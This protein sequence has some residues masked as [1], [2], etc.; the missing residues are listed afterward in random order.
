MFDA[1]VFCQG[2]DFI[3]PFSAEYQESSHTKHLN[4]ER[5]EIGKNIDIKFRDLLEKD[6]FKDRINLYF[7]ISSEHGDLPLYYRPGESPEK[8]TL[9]SIYTNIINTNPSDCITTIRLITEND[10]IQYNNKNNPIVTSLNVE[11]KLYESSVI[12]QLNYRFEIQR[13][14]SDDGY[15]FQNSKNYIAVGTSEI[16]YEKNNFRDC[17]ITFGPSNK[18]YSHYKRKYQ[19]IQSLLADTMS[20]I[21]ILI[22]IGK[23]ISKV[24]LKKKMN[25]DIVRNLINRNIYT[26]I[27]EC[28]LIE[29]N[30]KEKNYLKYK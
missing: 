27:K 19:K 17:L 24:L 3:D 1:S 2:N 14:E 21:N 11:S 26:K 25:K 29:K 6:E 4:L 28:S 12:P 5:C 16:F 8:Q 23:E 13:Y 10:I 7:C 20:I 18:P 30:K 9:I 15:F 22:G